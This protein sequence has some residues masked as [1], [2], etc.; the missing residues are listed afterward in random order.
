MLIPVAPATSNINDRLRCRRHLEGRGKSCDSSPTFTTT[1]VSLFAL[2]KQQGRHFRKPN[3]EMDEAGIEPAFDVNKN[4]R[5][6]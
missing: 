2:A 4:W 3:Q 6:V 5:D 1:Y